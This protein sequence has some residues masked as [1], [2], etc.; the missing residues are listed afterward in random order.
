[1]LA[2]GGTVLADNNQI[3]SFDASGSTAVLSTTLGLSDVTY[4]AG[5]TWLGY[6]NTDSSLEAAVGP[7]IEAG[8]SSWPTLAGNQMEQEAPPIP[9]LRHFLPVQP[10]AQYPVSQFESD[11]Q[12]VP[13]NSL[14][15]ALDKA[16]VASFLE[17]LD[18]PHDAIAF[19]GNALNYDFS[20]GRQSIGLCFSMD[21]LEKT[22][23][24]SD[25]S[26]PLVS[27]AGLTT[28]LVDP[29]L[30]FG[31]TRVVFVAS[32]NDGVIFEELWGIDATTPHQALIMPLNAAVGMQ[33]AAQAWVVIAQNLVAGQTV[34]N[35]VDAANAQLGTAWTVVGDGSVRL[36]AVE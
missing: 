13:G 31:K 33:Q 10:S 23:S 35:A 36:K 28:G 19:L 9:A 12:Q 4:Y 21:C 25:P 32:A 30:L 3:F 24:A 5:A 22:P 15:Y 34:Q 11:M 26:Y 6:S 17:Q 1:V 8:V 29:S 7:A 2:G 14:Y 20:G 18:A 16:S 27:P